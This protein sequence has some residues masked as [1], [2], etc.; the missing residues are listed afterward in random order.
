MEQ[1]IEQYKA[2]VLKLKFATVAKHGFA[3]ATAGLG[4]AAVLNPL[5]GIP[6]VFTGLGSYVVTEAMAKEIPERLKVAAMFHDAR[7]RFG[8]YRWMRR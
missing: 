5:F 3:I 2:A 4:V 6:G 8:W 7:K 1:T